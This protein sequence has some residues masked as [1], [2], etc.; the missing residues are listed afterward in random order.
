MEDKVI[1]ILEAT[2]SVLTTFVAHMKSLRF[3]RTQI[4]HKLSILIL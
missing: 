1:S 2:Y 3:A 4:A